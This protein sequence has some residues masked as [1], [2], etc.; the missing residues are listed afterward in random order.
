ME[1]L[2]E[3]VCGWCGRKLVVGEKE[4]IEEV[5]KTNFWGMVVLSSY[6]EADTGKHLE[7]N[8]CRDCKVKIFNELSKERRK[9]PD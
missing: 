8:V 5:L 6:N 9:H 1:F 4:N 7:S 3:E 2:Y